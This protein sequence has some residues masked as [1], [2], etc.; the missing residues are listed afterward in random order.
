[1]ATPTEDNTNMLSGYIHGIVFFVLACFPPHLRSNSFL[2]NFKE[3]DILSVI[4]NACL[5]VGTQPVNSERRDVLDELS[6][7]YNEEEGVQ[8]GI[9]DITN[10]KWPTGTALRWKNSELF[11]N[12]SGNDA[13]FAFFRRKEI[14][15]TCLLKP[16][17]V[18][19]P[20]AESYG[21]PETLPAIVPFINSVCGTFRN[22][23]GEISTAGEERNRNFTKYVSC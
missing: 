6:R 14:D 21:G 19:Y 3:R 4:E 11:Q 18:V 17:H 2:Y 15:R 16:S 13:N 8:V 10:F 1:M 9:L 20:F 12:V 7:V 5:F 23:D 22:I